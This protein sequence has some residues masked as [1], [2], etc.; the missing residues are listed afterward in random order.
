MSG[1]FDSYFYDYYVAPWCRIGPYIVGIVTGYILA[2][3]KN[4]IRLTWPVALTGWLIAIATALAALYGL[5]GDIGGKHPSSLG[6]AALYNSVAR[7]AWAAALCWLI[8]ACVS[9]WGGFVNTFLSWSPFVVL[10]RLTYMAYLIHMCLMNIYF[11][12]QDTLYYL[13]GV[14]IAVTF[15]AVLVATYGLSFIFMLG[16]ESPMIGLEKVFLPKRRKD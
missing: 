7:S 3:K 4:K 6:V 11:Q 12:S 8:V 10:G 5:R 13:T 2:S 15:M 1:S 16:L 14:N 9:G